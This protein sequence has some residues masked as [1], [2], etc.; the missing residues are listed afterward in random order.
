MVKGVDKFCASLDQYI[1]LE[2][3]ILLLWHDVLE[4]HSEECNKIAVA[5]ILRFTVSLMLYT[6][7]FVS[8]LHSW[9]CTTY[10]QV[11]FSRTVYIEKT[12]FHLKDS[13]YYYGLA[14]GKS[15]LLR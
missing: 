3:Y 9:L 6:F 14:P 10:L 8:V 7:Y 13:K 11:P 2:E 12:D 1:W 4:V 5:E 15:A